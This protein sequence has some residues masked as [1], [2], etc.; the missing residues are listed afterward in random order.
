MESILRDVKN[1]RIKDKLK[2]RLA[3]GKLEVGVDKID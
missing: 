3:N 2:I 1:V